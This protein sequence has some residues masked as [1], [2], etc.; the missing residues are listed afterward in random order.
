MWRNEKVG[1]IMIAASLLVMAVVVYLAFNYQLDLRLKQSRVQGIGLVRVGINSSQDM[2]PSTRT[3][4]IPWTLDC[5][6]RKSNW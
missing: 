2:P 1:L 3:R 6:R 4:P 5:L